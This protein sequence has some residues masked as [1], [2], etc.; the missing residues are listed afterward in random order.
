[1]KIVSAVPQQ[2]LS[3]N[4]GVATVKAACSFLYIGALHIYSA[5]EW[6]CS[7]PIHSLLG[8]PTFRSAKHRDWGG[9]R[10]RSCWGTNLL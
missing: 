7:H 1:M 2:D 10:T 4:T 6:D 8:N 5:V 9:D 3:R